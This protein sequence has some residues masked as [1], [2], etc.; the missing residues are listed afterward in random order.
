MGQAGVSGGR[1]FVVSPHEKHGF[2]GGGRSQTSGPRGAERRRA[3]AGAH[4][5]GVTPSKAV[6]SL[7]YSTSLPFGSCHDVRFAP[8]R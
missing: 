7:M 1:G 3:A 4:A 2:R 8:R 6:S 5:T